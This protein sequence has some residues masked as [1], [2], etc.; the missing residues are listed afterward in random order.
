MFTGATTFNQNLCD[1][2]MSGASDHSKRRF[3]DGG[4]N[5]F[6]IGACGTPP[7]YEPLTGYDELYGVVREYCNDEMGWKTHT[8]FEK[9]G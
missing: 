4:A 2:D 3:C 9:Y 5:C 6:P 7:L 1:W 8:K